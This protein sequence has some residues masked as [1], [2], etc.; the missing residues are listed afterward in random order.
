[1][2]ESICSAE[3]RPRMVMQMPAAAQVRKIV[4]TAVFSC[5]YSFAPNNLETTTAQPI[6]LPTA[7]DMK[8]MVMGWEAPTAASACSPMKRP[9][10][11]LSTI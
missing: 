7:T 8:I 11:M 3:R 5:P 6:L 9:A 10:M 2:A 4:Q 1:M